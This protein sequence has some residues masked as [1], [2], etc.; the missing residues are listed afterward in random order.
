MQLRH[1][2]RA[3]GFTLLL[4]SVIYT[5]A[6]AQERIGNNLSYGS[7]ATNRISEESPLVFYTFRGEEDDM[8]VVRV[9][10]TVEDLDPTV[11]LLSPSQQPL[12]INNDDPLASGN[13][14][15]RIAFRLPDDG[16]YS[17]VVGGANNTSGD[18][19]LL[20]DTRETVNNPTRLTVDDSIT[21]N[22]SDNPEPR[23]F[24]VIADAESMLLLSF[25]AEPLTYGFVAEVRDG[26]G[27]PVAILTGVPVGAVT[28]PRRE[29]EYAVVVSAPDP[30]GS[31]EV[32]LHAGQPVIAAEPQA[33]EV[34]PTAT[35]TATL[36]PSPTAIPACSVIANQTSVNIRTGP[37][38][39]FDSMGFL[40][41]SETLPAVGL[42]PTGDWVAVEID[43][44]R[45]WIAS[46]VTELMGSCGEIT[47]LEITATPTPIV[48]T[49][50]PT[51]TPTSTRT[52]TPSPTFTPSITPTFTPSLTPT[53]TFDPSRDAPFDEDYTRVLPFYAG[54]TFTEQISFP[55]G[56]HTD[57]IAISVE[58][59]NA[60]NT[61]TEYSFRLDCVGTGTESVVWGFDESNPD[62]AC[63]ETGVLV[64]TEASN[65]QLVVVTLPEGSQQA[66]VY[67]T[68]VITKL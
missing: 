21:V 65:D 50:T 63:G 4:L 52:P 62:K 43:G 44:E 47:E 19:L 15:A 42:S 27:Y 33:T 9:I 14:D 55:G 23:T 61:R 46:Q 3:F 24:R 37:G 66:L 2:L 58:G 51:L 18:F 26:N 13:G 36:T 34:I 53:P 64:F 29:G 28:L 16:I 5:P 38:I 40:R 7:A 60:L 20:L 1:V 59:F 39:E 45:G 25:E 56:D 35:A 48:P 57:V 49:D 67:Y 10:P 54:D 8:I 32:A 31:V 22:F 6:H 11:S 12:V 17:L 41:F 68:L 30:H